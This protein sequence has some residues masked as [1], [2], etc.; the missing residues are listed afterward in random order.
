MFDLV[1]T[2][3]NNHISSIYALLGHPQIDFNSFWDVYNQLRE[4]VD[5]E[6]LFRS[7]TGVFDEG[8]T[9]EDDPNGA[10]LPLSNLR[11]CEFGEGGVPAGRIVVPRSERPGTAPQKSL[12][13]VLT[14]P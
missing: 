10:Q 11:S 6:F 13:Q 1:P 2:S 5:E 3:C 12:I 8:H 14:S 7:S 4:A 9:S